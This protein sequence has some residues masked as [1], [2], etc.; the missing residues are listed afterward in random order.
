M[1]FGLEGIGPGF[2]FI[3]IAPT[4][5]SEWLISQLAKLQVLYENFLCCPGSSIVFRPL[6]MPVRSLVGHLGSAKILI[7]TFSLK[8]H[9]GVFCAFALDSWAL[10]RTNDFGFQEALGRALEAFG[11]NFR[12]LWGFLAFVRGW[13]PYTTSSRSISFSWQGFSSV[14]NRTLGFWSIHFSC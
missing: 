4:K 5:I 12:S 2:V 11:A 3:V 10:D 1:G 8:D 13:Q 9:R 6:E 7:C 14:S